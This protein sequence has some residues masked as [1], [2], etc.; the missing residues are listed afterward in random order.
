MKHLC[1]LVLKTFFAIA[2]GTFCFVAN[3]VE[4]DAEAAKA[5]AKE[6]NCFI[7]HAID[8]VKI[9]PAWNQVAAKLKGDPKAEE[10]LISHLTSGHLVTFPDGHKEAHKVVKVD[11]PNTLKNLVN[12]ILSL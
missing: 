7:C 1:S 6:N 11:D 5:L 3:A 9:G 2:I 4:V 12:W 10:K 8:K